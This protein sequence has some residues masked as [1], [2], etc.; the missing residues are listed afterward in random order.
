MNSDL[1]QSSQ[2]PA[3]FLQRVFER[4]KSRNPQL[5]LRA[6]ARHL[7]FSN[8]VHL[9]LLL[10][11]KRQLNSKVFS[12]IKAKLS[13]TETELHL[14]T[15]LMLRSRAE[16]LEEQALLDQSLTQL[17]PQLPSQTI[18]TDLLR[19]LRRWSMLAL[20]ELFRLKDFR[21][22]PKWMSRRL[23]GDLSAEQ[24]TE[25]LQALARLGVVRQKGQKWSLI[26]SEVFRSTPPDQ[27]SPHLRLL[28][29]QFFELGIESLEE[30]PVDQ[31]ELSTFSFAIDQ[32]RVQE[33]KEYLRRFRKEFA[34][35]FE[36]QE[37]DELYQ[38]NV[39]FFPLTNKK[40]NTYDQ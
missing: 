6:W 21:S 13:L 30:T 28:Q 18:T 22:D 19:V 25:T 8:H 39:Q 23:N 2:N 7:G 24:V 16:T 4:A 38:L 26:H 33:A 15:L 29:K 40:G 14:L 34:A 1:I 31:R 20:L 35:H 12:R 32:T 11:G 3:E 36:A 10:S 27:V 37:G 9:S 17:Q 5:S